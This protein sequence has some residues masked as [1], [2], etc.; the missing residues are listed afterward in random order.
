MEHL[1]QIQ[2]L[3]SQ[4]QSIFYNEFNNNKKSFG[5]AFFLCLF[6]GGFGIHKFYLDQAGKGILYLLFCWT[7]I[8]GILAFI[9][10]FTMSGQIKKINQ[11]IA[12]NII[13]K[14]N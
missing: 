3:T 8:P 4:Q 1:H 9:S 12:A 2:S 11:N 10:L 14:L 13:S 7:C 5:I 6:L